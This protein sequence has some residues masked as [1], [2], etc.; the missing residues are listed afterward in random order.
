MIHLITLKGSL[1]KALKKVIDESRLGH[2][3]LNN[4]DLLSNIGKRMF[5]M[6]L[7]G[8]VDG[9]LFKSTISDVKISCTLK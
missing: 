1:N 8:D 7:D 9:T 2:R 3:V 5:G 4:I 6:V